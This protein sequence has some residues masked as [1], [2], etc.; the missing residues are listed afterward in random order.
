MQDL[1]PLD[2]EEVKPRSNLVAK[3]KSS[4]N[5]QKPIIKTT[6]SGINDYSPPKSRSQ[7][8]NDIAGATI[9]VHVIGGDI[10]AE[11]L[12]EIESLHDYEA[13]HISFDSQL[14][15]IET[16]RRFSRAR[17]PTPIVL[18]HHVWDKFNAMKKANKPTVSNHVFLACYYTDDWISF[19]KASEAI[20]GIRATKFQAGV[21]SPPVVLLG[22]SRD[23]VKSG[24]AKNVSQDEAV[25]LASKYSASFIESKIVNRRFANTDSY[26]AI[27][28]AKPL[29]DGNE[30]A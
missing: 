1:E 8:Y 4:I 29:T 23:V 12:A 24:A 22:I 11:L 19:E 5:P 17:A 7:G 6:H 27:T 16:V 15:S 13:E 28:T 20:D 14:F 3:K 18:N 30:K 9:A 10:Q 21:P 2:L 25:A 26:L